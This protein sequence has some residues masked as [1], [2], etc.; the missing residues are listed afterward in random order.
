MTSDAPVELARF[1]GFDEAA[2]GVLDYLQAKLGFG[3]WMVTRT[4][5]DDWVILD[6]RAD[7]YDV[8]PRDVF[9]WT[10]SFCSRMVTGDAPRVAPRSAEI[11]AYRDAPIGQQMSIGA[12]I[13]V[14]LELRDGRLFGTMCG[15]DPEPKDDA[16]NAEL[17]LIELLGRLLATIAQIELDAQEEQRVSTIREHESADVAGLVDHRAWISLVEAEE[18]RSE[19]LASPASIIVVNPEYA[20]RGPAVGAPREVLAQ[21]VAAVVRGNLPRSVA[22]ALLD[23]SVG[24][25]LPETDAAKATLTIGTLENALRD[26]G[27]VAKFS[28]ASRTSSQALRL[29]AE[30]AFASAAS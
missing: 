29:A 4:S 6:A 5:G 30:R 24:L 19:A 2:N 14:P 3:L 21:A 16:I 27:I 11:P 28:S 12:Y 15:V 25:L 10:D 22:V 9:R 13:G 17:P 1:A 23:G 20:R 7:K 18:Q 26:D 8:S